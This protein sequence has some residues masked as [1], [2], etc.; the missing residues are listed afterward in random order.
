MKLQSSG[1]RSCEKAMATKKRGPAMQASGAQ[2]REIM[3]VKR[4]PDEQSELWATCPWDGLPEPSLPKKKKYLNMRSVYS[5][6]RSWTT[7]PKEK[8]GGASRCRRRVVKIKM[9]K[10]EVTEMLSLRRGRSYEKILADSDQ[11]NA[12]HLARAAAKGCDEELAA[13]K[14]KS[15]RCVMYVCAGGEV[16]WRMDAVDVG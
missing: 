2:E 11:K 7:R 12:K 10:N 8:K 6:A 15:Q 4:D 5:K 16:T 3:R 9:K 14:R 1:V 13:L